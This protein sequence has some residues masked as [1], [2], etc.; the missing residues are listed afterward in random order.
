MK[1]VQ[2]A[3][4]ILAGVVPQSVYSPEALRVTKLPDASRDEVLKV[5]ILEE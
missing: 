1:K 5:R 4:G 3:P 2:M